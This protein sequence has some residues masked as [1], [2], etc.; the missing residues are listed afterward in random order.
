M[1]GANTHGDGVDTHV[2]EVSGYS[3][4]YATSSGPIHALKN[5]DLR[6]AHGQT[7]GL[8]GESG[9]GKVLSGLGDPP[10]SSGKRDRE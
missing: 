10:I 1:A 8:V 4:S 2:L 6:V 9:S 3:L 5:I 7:H